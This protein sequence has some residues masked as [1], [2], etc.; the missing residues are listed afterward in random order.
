MLC[1]SPDVT[2]SEPADPSRPHPAFPCHGGIILEVIKTLRCPSACSSSGGNMQRNAFSRTPDLSPGM[3][4]TPMALGKTMIHLAS[5]LDAPGTTL[6][7]LYIF[8]SDRYRAVRTD[9]QA[10]QL[11]SAE[12]CFWLAQQA[13]FHAWAQHE[14]CEQSEGGPCSKAFTPGDYTVT[15]IELEAEITAYQLLLLVTSGMSRQ[16]VLGPLQSAVL[17]SGHVSIA[18]RLQS[19]FAL[20]DGLAYLALIR[21]APYLVQCLAHQHAPAMRCIALEQLAEAY[22]PSRGKFGGAMPLSWLAHALLL[23]SSQQAAAVAV[24]AGFHL[25]DHDRFHAQKGFKAADV[26]AMPKEAKQHLMVQQRA[27]CISRMSLQPLSAN[28]QFRH[29]EMSQEPEAVSQLSRLAL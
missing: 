27:D 8:I 13:R 19:A 11:S 24:A 18:L 1:R 10:Q 2:I 23:N 9:I 14:L 17:S 7:S 3:V 4:R 26:P 6:Q 28:L 29:P 15:D 25:D 20:G 16:E 22:P 12:T 21:E 5:L